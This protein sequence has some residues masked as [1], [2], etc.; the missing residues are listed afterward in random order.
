MTTQEIMLADVIKTIVREPNVTVSM[1]TA[2]SLLTITV[3]LSTE[4]SVYFCKK[5]NERVVACIRRAYILVI[6]EYKYKGNVTYSFTQN[7]S[8]T[9]EGFN[10]KEEE[11]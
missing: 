10:F 7:H 6:V 2:V 8:N 1:P 3:N 9:L 5:I 4:Q 11:K